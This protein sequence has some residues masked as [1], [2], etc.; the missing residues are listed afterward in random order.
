[1]YVHA[2]GEID[3]LGLA[4]N[5]EGNTR[6]LNVRLFWSLICVALKCLSRW[7]FIV[8]CV[9][10]NLIPALRYVVAPLHS[11]ESNKII[12]IYLL[13]IMCENIARLFGP[14]ALLLIPT[15][16]NMYSAA[17]LKGLLHGLRSLSY[18]ERLTIWYY[19]MLPKSKT[20]T[21]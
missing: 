13:F 16:W 11:T 3:G 6:L 10:K 1:M 4:H 2:A 20:L 18:N 5:S 15:N 9:R 17:S 14:P 21:L 7:P 19:Q 12:L 8:R